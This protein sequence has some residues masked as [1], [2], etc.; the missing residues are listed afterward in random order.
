MRLEREEIIAAW[1]AAFI[2]V[3]VFALAYLLL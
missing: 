3:T 1:C 2:G